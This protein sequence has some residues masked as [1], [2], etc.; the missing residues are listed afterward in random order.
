MLGLTAKFADLWNAWLIFGRSH[1]DEVRPLTGRVDAACRRIGRDPASLGRSV[2]LRVALG[3]SSNQVRATLRRAGG[4]LAG[5]RA[6]AVPLTGSPSALAEALAAF[7]AEGIT[8]VQL[9]MQ[10]NSL[11]EVEEFG[12]VLQVLDRM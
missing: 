8:H 6:S 5:F 2:A 4:R 9:E 3:G 11:A 7:A 1:P 12:N 10:S